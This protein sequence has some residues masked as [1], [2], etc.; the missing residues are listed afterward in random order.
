MSNR[1]LS[2]KEIGDGMRS[3]QM[4]VRDLRE[5]GILTKET[6][7]RQDGSGSGIENNNGKE[8]CRGR[9]G[10]VEGVA[11]AL[12]EED[13]SKKQIKIVEEKSRT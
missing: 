2:C 10:W 8:E 6:R 1:E 3:D 7:G 13:Q 4:G 5:H 11:C 9:K 12:E